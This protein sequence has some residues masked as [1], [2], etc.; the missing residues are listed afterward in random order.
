MWEAAIGAAAAIIVGFASR[1]PT[2]SRDAREV[3]AIARDVEL[4]DKMHDSGARLALR[5]EIELRVVRLIVGREPRIRTRRRL[6]VAQAITAI[7]GGALGVA[8]LSLPE[9]L[10]N[11]EVPGLEAVVGFVSVVGIGSIYVAS[12]MARGRARE[13]D[14]LRET[15]QRL[16]DALRSDAKSSD[17]TD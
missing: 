7:I 1:L 4:A 17:A 12:T 9:H 14:R 16:D 3:A 15:R 13:D 2:F 11:A 10:R 8:I 6:L 5:R